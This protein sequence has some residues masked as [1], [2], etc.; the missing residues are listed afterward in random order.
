MLFISCTSSAKLVVSNGVDLSKYKYVAFGEKSTGDGELYDLIM[1]VENE[2]SNTK[3]QTITLNN[4]PEDYYGYTLTPDIHITS[5]K[6]NGGHTYITINF[7]DI[8]LGRDIAVLKGNGFGMTLSDDQRLA[9][10]AVRD[11]L[12]SIFGEN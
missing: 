3:L 2:I 4:A 7:R 1:L 6:W 10:K 5:E 9:L 8:S 12:Q 11:K